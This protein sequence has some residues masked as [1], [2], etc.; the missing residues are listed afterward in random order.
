L[1]RGLGGKKARFYFSRGEI[2]HA[3]AGERIG[4]Q[5]LAEALGWESGDFRFSPD[6]PAPRAT[7]EMPVQFALLEAA[8]L[9][10]EALHA[11]N[12]PDVAAPAPVGVEESPP[13]EQLVPTEA[14]PPVATGVEDHLAEPVTFPERS[15]EMPQGYKDSTEILDAIVKIPG[16]DGVVV[17]GR[18]GFAIESAGASTRLNIDTLGAAL[19]LAINGIEDMGSE[20]KV[21]K[22]QDLH[23]EYGRAVLICHPIG[24]AVCAI[25]APDASKLGIIRHKAKPLFDELVKFF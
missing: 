18:D 6:V 14:P 15:E 22:F 8:R 13:P 17:C 20:L 3:D 2:V 23:I 25:V 11:R 1:S 16:V 7:I 21:D 10:D 9:R 24:D 4:L 19:A 12:A 5:A